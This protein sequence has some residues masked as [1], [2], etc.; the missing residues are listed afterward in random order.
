MRITSVEIP[1]IFRSML[2]VLGGLPGAVLRCP[3]I[4]DPFHKILKFL[5]VEATIQDGRYL[6]L[7]FAVHLDR[8]RRRLSAMQNFVL[9][10]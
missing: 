4:A 10:V 8:G 2:E 1:N 6:V 9:D 3:F 7:D 5:A